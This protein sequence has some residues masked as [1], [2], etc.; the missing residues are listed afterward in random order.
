MTEHQQ[1]LEIYLKGPDW[2]SIL[3]WLKN[4]F[5]IVSINRTSTGQVLDLLFE[6]KP[7][8]CLLVEQ[9]VKGGYSSIWFKNNHTPWLNDLECAN[10]AHSFLQI[11]IRCSVGNW[12]E[13]SKDDDAWHKINHGIT[14]TVNW[15]T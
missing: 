1:D 15:Q 2:D 12:S 9:A 6:N 14:E 5:T 11:E 3:D 8:Q 7:L 13:N 10:D 4:H